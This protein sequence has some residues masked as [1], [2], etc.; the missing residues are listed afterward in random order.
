MTKEEWVQCGLPP[1]PYVLNCRKDWIG[2][3]FQAATMDANF[4]IALT[5][6]HISAMVQRPAVQILSRVG[7]TQG[8]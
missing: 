6:A 1:P 8:K 7:G 2:G 4:D 3:S 5:M